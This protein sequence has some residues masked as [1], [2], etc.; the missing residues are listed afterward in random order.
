MKPRFLTTLS[1]AA[2]AAA[3]LVC[4]TGSMRIARDAGPRITRIAPGAFVYRPAGE[5]RRDGMVVDAPLQ[6]RFAG[7]ALE[8]MTFAVSQREYS[9]CVQVGHCA[10]STSGAEA[11]LPQTEVSF[12][13]AQAYAA[14]LS[15]ETGRSWRLPTDAEWVRAAAE[16]FRDDALG[17][18]V[19]TTDPA[20]RWLV[21]YNRNVAARDGAEPD[22]QGRGAYGLNSL[23]VADMA[24]NVWEWTDTCLPNV[25]LAIDGKGES[26]RTEYC[27]VRL[28]EGRHRT[29]V[30]DFVR[31]A[32][33]GGCAVG[34]PPD[35]LGFRLV[36][37]PA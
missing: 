10:G 12:N 37:D 1:L 4:G 18:A 22:L 28:L 11:D 16:R 29:F 31:D 6:T 13:D 8:I 30:I 32:R 7:A 26:S 35:H 19:S 33:V 24:G 23:G 25:Q 36:R 34:L 15:R 5:F 17:D 9:R 14:W 3:G 21:Q 20:E 27:G 2:L